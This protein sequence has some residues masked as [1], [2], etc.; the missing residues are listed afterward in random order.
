MWNIKTFT[1]LNKQLRCKTSTLLFSYCSRLAVLFWQESDDYE[2]PDDQE[3]GVDSET[4]DD[5]DSIDDENVGDYEPP[6]SNDDEK[7]RNA[8][9]PSKSIPAPSEYIGKI[10]FQKVKSLSKKKLEDLQCN[11]KQVY[12]VGLMLRKA[13]SNLSIALEK[14][15]RNVSNQKS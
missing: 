4:P 8:I 1:V 11:P 10:H 9:F 3:P 2:C 5:E 6:P 14:Q 7:N 12:S 15:N 13:F